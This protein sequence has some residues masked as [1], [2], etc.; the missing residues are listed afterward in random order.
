MVLGVAL[1]VY[2]QPLDKK[3]RMTEQPFMQVRCM[4]EGYWLFLHVQ[5]SKRRYM[6]LREDLTDTTDSP[7][8]E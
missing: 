2:P 5:R 7:E 3:F 6:R 8:F 4:P 1:G